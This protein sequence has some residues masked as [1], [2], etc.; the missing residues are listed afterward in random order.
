MRGCM[1][2]SMAGYKPGYMPSYMPGSM[3]PDL[4]DSGLTLTSIFLPSEF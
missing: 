3:R 1:A 4:M 2:G